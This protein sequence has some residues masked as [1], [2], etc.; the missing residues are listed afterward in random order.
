LAG[1]RKE[2]IE[3]ERAKKALSDPRLLSSAPE[4]R[5]AA[6]LALERAW[7]DSGLVVPLMTADRWFIVDPDLRGVVVRPDGVPLVD[8]AYFTGAYLGVNT[9]LPGMPK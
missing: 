4:D 9:T 8:S 5:V 7:I 2:L 3:D 1:Q 6:A